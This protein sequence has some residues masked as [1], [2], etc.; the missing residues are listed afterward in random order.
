MRGSGVG[1]A[2]TAWGAD[3]QKDAATLI[4]RLAR[5]D[6]SHL[7]A[8]AIV[9]FLFAPAPQ[10]GL[11]AQGLD[12]EGAID[13][14]V[15]SD[16][17]TNQEEISAEEGRIVAAIEKSAEAAAEVRRKFSLDRVEIVFVPDMDAE[18]AKTAEKLAEFASEIEELRESIQSS[19][20]F[21]HAV[22]SR[23]VM[24]GDVVAL[25]FDDANG[26]TIFVRGEE[27]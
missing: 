9:A 8:V 25:E 2:G 18:G 1:I 15:G 21:Y 26:V 16:V 4:I 20:M 11:M 3:K 24:L 17:T 6:I 14:I 13:T 27:P 23:S 10:M 19:A 7:H 22:D 5:G 12:A